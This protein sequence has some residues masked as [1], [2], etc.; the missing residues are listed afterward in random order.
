MCLKLTQFCFKQ[1]KL[2]NVSKH[3]YSSR[4]SAL[5]NI[6]DG[7]YYF[8]NPTFTAIDT[9][10]NE[11]YVDEA[12]LVYPLGSY[13]GIHKLEFVYFT[14]TDLSVSL[15]TSLDS[16]FLANVHSSLDV[17]K[18]KYKVIFEPLIQDL[19]Q[20]LDQGIQFQG[21][22]YKTLHFGNF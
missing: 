16:L 20:L 11:L 1:K 9:I 18:Y 5:C 12:E 7:F 15:Q 6:Q 22:A 2:G 21:N 3:F 19:K 13:T 17:E 10:I 4:D 14:I 8:S